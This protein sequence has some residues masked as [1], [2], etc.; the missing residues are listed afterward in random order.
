MIRPQSNSNSGRVVRLGPGPG[1]RLFLRPPTLKASNFEALWS[2]YSIFLAWKDLIPFPK[3][4]KIKGSG[5]NF[6][7]GFALSKTPHLH[8]AYSV[9]VR[10]RKSMTVWDA[11]LTSSLSLRVMVDLKWNFE[12]FS[13]S[14]ENCEL[15]SQEK[16]LNNSFSTRK[17]QNNPEKILF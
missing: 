17:V 8:R 7:V 9:T 6:I 14:Q 15:N 11:I 2:T 13:N 4:T 1:G 3:Y 5:S 10:K 16:T 12:N